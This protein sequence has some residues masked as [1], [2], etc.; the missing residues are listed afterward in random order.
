ML[1][2]LFI[3]SPAP[4]HPPPTLSWYWKCLPPTFT[5][6]SHLFQISGLPA[7]R[8]MGLT[9]SYLIRYFHVFPKF[10]S[11]LYFSLFPLGP[12]KICIVVANNHLCCD[13]LVVGPNKILLWFKRLTEDIWQCWIFTYIIVNVTSK[14]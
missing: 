12:P 13:D 7:G 4:S 2:L 8:L 3:L 14:I 1:F 10:G 6:Q 5:L 11:L 9:F